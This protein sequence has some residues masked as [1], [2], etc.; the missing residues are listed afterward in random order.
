[1][2]SLGRE[3]G[4]LIEQTLEIGLCLKTEAL[5][6]LTASLAQALPAAGGELLVESIADQFAPRR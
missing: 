6:R 1:M 4:N 2:E 3:I 5:A